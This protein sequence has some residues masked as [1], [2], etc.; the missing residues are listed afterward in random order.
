MDELKSFT[1]RGCSAEYDN[2]MK[3]PIR[4]FDSISKLEID[5]DISC[6]YV[7]QAHAY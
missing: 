1:Y 6:R 3:M 5:P 4:R 2:L 7:I